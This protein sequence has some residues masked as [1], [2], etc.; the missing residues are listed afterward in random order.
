[1]AEYKFKGGRVVEYTHP[2]LLDDH[3]AFGQSDLVLKLNVQ[4]I[5]LNFL[6]MKSSE[7]LGGLAGY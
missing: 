1:M 6:I 7:N 3:I 2:R 5:E 4:I